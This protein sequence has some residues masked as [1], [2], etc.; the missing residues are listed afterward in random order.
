MSNEARKHS[1]VGEIVNLMSVD[2]QRLQDATSFL[3]VIW[4]TPL[5]IIIALYLLWG[6]LGPSVL[7]GLAIMILMIP[8]NGVLTSYQRKLQVR[9][10]RNKSLEK[11]FETSK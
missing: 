3:W 7:G 6:I 11:T 5:Q 2:A 9:I 4:S 10:S 8:L 1:T